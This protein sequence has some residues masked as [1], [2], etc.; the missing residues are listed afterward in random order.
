[1]GMHGSAC[2]RV[3]QSSA[4]SPSTRHA[5]NCRAVHD[6][7]HAWAQRTRCARWPCMLITVVWGTRLHSTP[8]RTLPLASRSQ[9]ERRLVRRGNLDHQTVKAGIYWTSA[10]VM[11]FICAKDMLCK[12]AMLNI[13]GLE[14]TPAD[15]HGKG[16]RGW[17]QE[18]AGFPAVRH[19][20]ERRLVRRGHLD[21][22]R[23]SWQLLDVTRCE[24]REGHAVQGGHVE[25]VSRRP[26]CTAASM[27]WR[28][29]GHAHIL[30]GR[31]CWLQ[32]RRWD[33]SRASSSR[34]EARQARGIWTINQ[35]V[36]TGNYCMSYGEGLCTDDLTPVS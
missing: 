35:A 16:V 34:T 2:A 6:G 7:M 36:K 3:L 20:A 24:G 26:P 14:D 33:S 4:L 5:C 17:F 10:D 28:I 21:H 27:V 30:Y 13:T 11:V 29:G 22:Q 23:E 15:T 1:M 19:Q 25:N 32:R 9:A 12:V 8:Q 18:D 31:L